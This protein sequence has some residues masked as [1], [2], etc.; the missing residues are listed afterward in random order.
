MALYCPKAYTMKVIEKKI[1]EKQYLSDIMKELAKNAIYHKPTGAGIT[2][3]ELKTHRHSIIIESNTPVIQG[4]CAE[5]N[6][7][8]RRKLVIRGVY[9]GITVQEIIDYL[10]S[11]VEYIKIMTTPESYLKVVQA[12]N[13]LDM[14][15]QVYNTYFML[16]DECER[17]I[18]DVDYRKSII[19]PMD[20]FFIFK[21][22]AFVSA[23][24]IIPS[25]PRFKQQNFKYIRVKPSYDTI[26]KVGLT[27]TNNTLL[28]FK[29]HIEENPRERYFIFLNSTKAICTL[30]NYLK[31][32]CKDSYIF[33]SEESKNKLKLNRITNAKSTL[34]ESVEFRKY[35]FFTSRFNSAVDI[36]NVVE[37]YIII[38]TD[39]FIAEH[40]KVDPFSEVQQII[41][42][43]RK[44]E[45]GTITRHLTH[46]TNIDPKLKSF[47][48]NEI[49]T[50]VDRMRYLHDT[51]NSFCKS[52][53]NLFARIIVKEMMEKT[54]FANYINKDGT[55]NYFMVDNA[56]FDGKMNGYYSKEEHLIASYNATGE[57]KLTVMQE[58]YELTDAVR[59]EIKASKAK[60]KSSLEL[61][62]PILNSLELM[63][64]NNPIAIEQ[65]EEIKKEHPT[66]YSTFQEIGFERAAELE[67]KYHRIQAEI[68][69]KKIERE[70]TNFQLLTHIKSAFDV[71]ESYTLAQIK[72]KLKAGIVKFNLSSLK[73]GIELLEIYFDISARTYIGTEN[74]KSKYGYTILKSKF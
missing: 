15:E 24:P 67:F 32:D 63:G 26:Q 29:K 27:I 59:A 3:L 73:A 7:R 51:L 12:F 11:G 44:P 57:F 19:I 64:L 37:P 74:G 14:M 61:L 30:I 28:S 34:V 13:E 43:F 39:L 49:L 54:T 31:I 5:F 16:F 71:G 25:D 4:K 40:T 38:V 8:N 41:G 52:S 60:L 55:T 72:K 62:M 6:G 23:T 36:L 22:K 45:N 21:N 65:L 69:S 1:G 9:E 70:G 20:D 42:R 33:C 56:V 53:T 48:Q 35:N 17:T 18:Q 58:S 2:R 66:A 10:Q 47:S 46:I 50:D 68:A